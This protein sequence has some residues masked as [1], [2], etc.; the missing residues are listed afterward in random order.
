[1]FV[2]FNALKGRVIHGNQFWT[3]TNVADGLNA[4]TVCIEVRA[5]FFPLAHFPLLTSMQM[6][7]FSLFMMWAFSW[8]KYRVEAG[9]RHTSIWRPLWDS[10][11][12]CTQT[13]LY[14]SFALTHLGTTGDFAVEIGSGLVYF[15]RRLTG[16]RPPAPTG[17][18]FGGASGVKGYLSEKD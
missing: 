6:I 18:N 12:L 15:A 10:I 5:A 17:K 4:F 7:F 8:N 9:E 1:M 13:N 3:A 16:R 2:K 11:N 14:C